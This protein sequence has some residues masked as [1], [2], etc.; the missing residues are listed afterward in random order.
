M[1]PYERIV[2]AVQHRQPDR[3]PIDYIATPEFQA[4][5]KRHFGVEDDE[6]IYRKVGAD[7]RRVDGRFVG[8]SDMT[9]AAGV[10]AQG[11]DFLG[12]VWRPV[13]NEFGVYNEI[14]HHPLGRV[15]TVKE[16][17]EYSW[18]SVDWFDF[19]HLKEHIGRLNREHRYAILYFA[20]GAFETP[21]YMRGMEQFLMDL[22]ERPDIA[23]A[24]ARKA[25]EFYQKRALRAMEESGGQIDIIGSGGDLG[26]QRGM[27]LSPHLWR[28][29]IKPYSRGLI[30]PFKEMG[31]MTYY[32][33][34]G[35]IVP[36]IEDLIEI[37]MDILDPVQP[38]AEGMNPFELKKT[39]GTRLTLHGGID[40]QELL[41][42]GSPDEVYRQVKRIIEIVGRDGGYITCPAHA[43]QPDTPVENVLAL[44]QAAQEMA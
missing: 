28:K 9:G 33:S 32:H 38:N 22:M 6:T 34:C 18:P 40:E 15:T 42:H 23:E 37:G 17:E 21:W 41:P 36:V 12:I 25:A 16:V 8:P 3:A 35:S 14:A 4:L 20:G 44:Y 26:S 1:E 19:S 43:I 27:M 11:R 31:V 7:I 13:K 5:L 24:I 29:H 2:A 39:F 10:Y 30:R